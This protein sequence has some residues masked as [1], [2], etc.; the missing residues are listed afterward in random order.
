MVLKLPIKPTKVK[1]A[2]DQL[3]VQKDGTIIA[4]SDM[5]EQHAKNCLCLLIR[6]IRDHNAKNQGKNLLK[7]II[8]MKADEMKKEAAHFVDEGEAF[9]PDA[10]KWGDK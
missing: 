2:D 8:K 7:K 1:V 10:D 6:R 9:D 5:T 3:W 4:V